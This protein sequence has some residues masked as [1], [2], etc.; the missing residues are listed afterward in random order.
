MPGGRSVPVRTSGV[1]STDVPVAL[2]ELWPQRRLID[3]LLTDV[4]V[5][6]SRAL[7]ICGVGGAGKTLMLSYLASAADGLQLARASGSSFEAGMH[8]SGLHQLLMPMLGA[9]TGLPATQRHAV[10]AAFGGD[11]DWPP[12]RFHLGLATLGLLSATA[13]ERGLLCLVDDVER[14]DPASIETLAFVARRLDS[15]GIGLVFAERQAGGGGVTALRGL[16]STFVEPFDDGASHKLLASLGTSHL[17][18][19]VEARVLRAAGGNPL[20]LRELYR[21]LTAAQR[22]GREPLHEQLRLTRRLSDSLLRE[23]RTY[24]RQAQAYLL[25]VALESDPV[26]ARLAAERLG[27]D[28]DASELDD[29]HEVL[30]EGRDVQFR[31]ALLGQ[32]VRAR[33]S[34]SAMYRAHLAL[35][36]V[37]QRP[38]DADRRAWHRAAITRGPDEHAAA[39]LEG[40][41]EQSRSRGG[42]RMAAA[43]LERAAVLTPDGPVRAR[44]LVSAAE[45]AF[46][47]GDAGAALEV[48][49]RAEQ[50][51]TDRSEAVRLSRLHAAILRTS[52]EE[53]QAARLLVQAASSVAP[54]DPGLARE[55]YLEALQASLRTG[56]SGAGGELAQVQRAARGVTRP[57]GGRPT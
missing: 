54:T 39:D 30:R 50:L 36:E 9:V 53:A 40:A 3:Q 34:A 10:E 47:A 52:G 19:R 33:A 31:S 27:I 14:V 22:R 1:S 24:P 23:V 42:A 35:G 11:D 25:V 16:P 44:R 5:G 4:R 38:Q 57:A 18:D 51:G 41:A 55:I 15:E 37:S 43:F 21:G 2:V 6:C 7:L 48:A 28:P 20:A 46:V 29:A 13:S 32:A 56:S 45:S 8:F 12:D 17:D 49:S 26:L